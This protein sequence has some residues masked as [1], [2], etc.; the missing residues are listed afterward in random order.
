MT[1]SEKQV[2]IDAVLSALR[3]NSRTIEQLTPVASLSASD[4]FEV[5]GGEG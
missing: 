2:I 3:T 1:E 4:Y 5:N